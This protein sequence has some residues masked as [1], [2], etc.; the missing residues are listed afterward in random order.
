MV[1]DGESTSRREGIHAILELNSIG[2]DY[3]YRHPISGP[4][5]EVAM[6]RSI[7]KGIDQTSIGGEIPTNHNDHAA[8]PTRQPTSLSSMIGN[9]LNQG[10]RKAVQDLHEKGIETYGWKDGHVVS[11]KP[12]RK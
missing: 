8:T 5:K 9:L 4:G 3:W 7:R 11:T 2:I 10:R 6:A 12:A 1:A